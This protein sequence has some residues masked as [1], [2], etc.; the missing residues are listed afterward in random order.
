MQTMSIPAGTA[1]FLGAP[2]NPIDGSITEALSVFLSAIDGISEAHL[3]QCYVTGIVDPP[4]QIL[5]VVPASPQSLDEAL[6][7]LDRGLANVLPL[8]KVLD[9][10]PIPADHELLEDVRDAGCQLKGMAAR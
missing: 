2:A 5:V 4:A 8:S 1:V 9:V 6:A 7:E 10:W 3:P